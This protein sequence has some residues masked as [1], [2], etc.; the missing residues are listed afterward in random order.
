MGLGDVQQNNN[1]DQKKQRDVVFSPLVFYNDDS[2]LG[3][4][5]VLSGILEMKITPKSKNGTFDDKNSISIYLSQQK[6]YTLERALG[7]LLRDISE[8][9]IKTNYGVCNN[10][11]TANIEFGAICEG[12]KLH[13]YASIYKYN[14]DGKVYD[15]YS[16]KFTNDDYIIKNFSVNNLSYDSI[17]VDDM[18]LVM[19]RNLLLEYV[20]GMTGGVAYG[21]HYCVGEFKYKTSELKKALFGGQQKQIDQP[22]TNNSIFTN[23]NGNGATF[24]NGNAEDLFGEFE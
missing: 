6:A 14:Q 2:A 22:T 23:N 10:K 19:I 13:L 1:Q 11:K 20:K 12:D 5:F 17:P 3:F 9:E 16:F 24:T 7:M 21:I 15:Q 8:G 18:P 4:R